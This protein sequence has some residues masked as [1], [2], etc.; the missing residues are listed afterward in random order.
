MGRIK[1][2]LI[3]RTTLKLFKDHSDEF[4]T[5]FDENK[6]VVEKFADTKSKKLRNIIAGYVT[7]LKKKDTL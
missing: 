1:T 6:K 7:R 4:K 3:K 2:T 5:S